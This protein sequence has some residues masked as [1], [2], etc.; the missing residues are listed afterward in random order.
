[1]ENRR[2][3]IAMSSKAQMAAVTT[4]RNSVRGSIPGRLKS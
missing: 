2:L 1:L 3:Q 4:S